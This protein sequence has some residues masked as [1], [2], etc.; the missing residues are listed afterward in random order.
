MKYELKGK[1][2]IK[3]QVGETVKLNDVLY[4]SQEVNNLLSI[5][6]LVSKGSTMGYTK[7]KMTIKKNGFNMTSR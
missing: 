6:R 5:S 2:N 3:V 4:V 7:D 1:V